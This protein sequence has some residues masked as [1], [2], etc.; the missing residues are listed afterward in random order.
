MLMVNPDAVAEVPS[1]VN[2]A[3]LLFT[4]TVT[5]EFGSMTTISFRL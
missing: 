5:G 3:Q 2:E 1:K 4:A